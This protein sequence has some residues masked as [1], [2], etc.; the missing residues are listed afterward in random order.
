MV[1]EPRVRHFSVCILIPRPLFSLRQIAPAHHYAHFPQIRVNFSRKSSCLQQGLRRHPRALVTLP[2]DLVQSSCFFVLL[3]KDFFIWTI[4]KAFIEFITRLLP[5]DV[6]FFWSQDTWDL[7]FLAR[8]RTH[9]P[10]TG[11]QSFNHWTAREVPLLILYLNFQVPQFS[12]IFCVV[13]QQDLFLAGFLSGKFFISDF[14]LYLDFY[15]STYKDGKCSIF[16][17]RLFNF[18]S[19][20]IFSMSLK[21]LFFFLREGFP[22]VKIRYFVCQVS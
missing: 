18:V 5:F 6:L 21:V 11:R 20:H 9:T 7:S 2:A 1:G 16:Q 22:E 10:C 8:D 17:K 3:F 14:L 19:A 13:L 4:F 12:E 15:V